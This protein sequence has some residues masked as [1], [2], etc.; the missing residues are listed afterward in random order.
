M[1]IEIEAVE[2]IEELRKE[3]PQSPVIHTAYRH[4]IRSNSLKVIDAFKLGIRIYP[5]DC[6]EGVERFRKLIEK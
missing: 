1:T 2:L 4:S 6:C 3:F 5:K